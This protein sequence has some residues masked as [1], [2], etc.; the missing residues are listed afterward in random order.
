MHSVIFINPE[1]EAQGV[2]EYGLMYIDKGI[3]DK[4]LVG[5]L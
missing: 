2:N 4:A 1:G 5:M 3:S